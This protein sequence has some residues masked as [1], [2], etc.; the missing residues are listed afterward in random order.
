M[1][2]T[3]FKQGMF[4]NSIGILKLRVIEENLEI[5]WMLNEKGCEKNGKQIY[6]I[7]GS[8]DEI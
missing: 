6:L 2:L 5:K 1:K 4:K 7:T 3:I 8:E